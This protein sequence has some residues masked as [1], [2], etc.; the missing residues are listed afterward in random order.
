MK[1]F[2]P[3]VDHLK[4]QIRLNVRTKN[5]EIKVGWAS[6]VVTMP[7]DTPTMDTSTPPHSQTSKHTADLGAIQKAEDFVRAFMLGFNVDDALALVRLD[8]LFVDSFEVTDGQ[9]IPIVFYKL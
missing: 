3:I 9:P 4:L 2:T 6:A 5:V 8:D 7:M 1:I